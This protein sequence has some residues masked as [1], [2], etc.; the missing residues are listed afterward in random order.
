MRKLNKRFVQRWWSEFNKL[1]DASMKIV[2]TGL[3]RGAVVAVALNAQ[4][5]T[6]APLACCQR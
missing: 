5:S 6:A 2:S 1:E 3:T 4:P